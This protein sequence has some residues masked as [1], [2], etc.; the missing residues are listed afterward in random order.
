MYLQAYSLFSH[1]VSWLLSILVHWLCE[2]LLYFKVFRSTLQH[3]LCKKNAF[4]ECQACLKHILLV[5]CKD[6]DWRPLVITHTHAHTCLICQLMVSECVPPRSSS[7]FRSVFFLFRVLFRGGWLADRGW[8]VTQ[9]SR[10]NRTLWS[11]PLSV[12]LLI[13]QGYLR[14]LVSEASHMNDSKVSSSPRFKG[15]KPNLLLKKRDARKLFFNQI[16]SLLYNE[17][18]M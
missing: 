2:N 10:P 5:D 17:S 18:W 12:S 7:L 6:S 4:W 9:P 3:R 11:S 8:S 1:S 16:R 15:L 13:W 14:G